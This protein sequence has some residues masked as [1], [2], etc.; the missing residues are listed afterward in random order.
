MFERR[1]DLLSLFVRAFGRMWQQMD[2][3]D[4]AIFCTI[5]C[6][7]ISAGVAITAI[8]VGIR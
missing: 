1:R 6:A 8:T 5:V 3:Q 2:S 4:K 7:V